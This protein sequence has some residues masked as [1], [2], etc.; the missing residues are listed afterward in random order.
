MRATTPDR[1]PI[2][3]ALAPGLLVLTGLGSRGF[4]AAPLLAALAARIDSQRFATAD[5]LAKPSP[6]V[7][8]SLRG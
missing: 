5:P 8:G 1:L 6:G 2:A 7:D 3:G 4:C